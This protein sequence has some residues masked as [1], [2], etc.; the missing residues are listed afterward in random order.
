M[1]LLPPAEEAA[2]QPQL[3]SGQAKQLGDGAG[4][5]VRE[6]ELLEEFEELER[7]QSGSAG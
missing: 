5:S 1:G 2:P 4:A 7:G 3:G 6:A